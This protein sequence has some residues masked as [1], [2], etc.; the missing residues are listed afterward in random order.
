MAI[1]NLGRGSPRFRVGKPIDPCRSKKIAVGAGK[2]R[3]P[4]I[5]CVPLGAF[6]GTHTVQ[7]DFGGPTG[8]CRTLSRVARQQSPRCVPHACQS[9]DRPAWDRLASVTLPPPLRSQCTFGSRQRS[10][11]DRPPAMNREVRFI[12]S[13]IA[14]SPLRRDCSRLRAEYKPGKKSE[15]PHARAR[16]GKRL[17]RFFRKS[18]NLRWGVFCAQREGLG[19][20]AGLKSSPCLTLRG[21]TD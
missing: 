1:F 9:T 4:A 5:W 17:T 12:A 7:S 11:A 8:T 21:L 14:L 13:F 6:A 18:G 20:K 3:F 15:F 10:K 16:V 2:R 19:A